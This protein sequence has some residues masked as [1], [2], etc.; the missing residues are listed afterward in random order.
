MMSVALIQICDRDHKVTDERTSSRV[1]S[2]VASPSS[3]QRCTGDGAA[4]AAGPPAHST[5]GTGVTTGL[6]S[7]SVSRSDGPYLLGVH[8]E[9]PL[10][11][12]FIAIRSIVFAVSALSILRGER[13]AK[14]T[15]WRSRCMCLRGGA[16]AEGATRRTREHTQSIQSHATHA[17]RRDSTKY[18][19]VRR[20]PL[21]SN[22]SSGV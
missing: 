20:V 7:D 9:S 12:V 13:E 14:S 3:V 15:P 10:L 19:S 1:S 6:S 16:R 11:S 18:R 8:T 17:S 5:P 4:G 22:A 2:R 21:P